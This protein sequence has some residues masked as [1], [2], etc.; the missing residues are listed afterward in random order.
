[1]ENTAK[2]RSPSRS[3]YLLKVIVNVKGSQEC[4]NN[5]QRWELLRI[6]IQVCHQLLELLYAVHVFYILD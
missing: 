2:L 3:D 5:A 6:A 1:M 4:I